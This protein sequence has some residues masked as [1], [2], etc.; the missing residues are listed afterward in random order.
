MKQLKFFTSQS[1]TMQA[2]KA[3]LIALG[4][5]P[6]KMRVFA[7]DNSRHHFD[8]LVMAS[9]RELEE[10][11]ADKTTAIYAVSCLLASFGIYAGWFGFVEFFA[12]VLLFGAVSMARH[13]FAKPKTL[14]KENQAGDSVYFFVV[15]V[16]DEKEARVSCL[17]KQCPGLIA[18]M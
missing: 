10:A 17:T 6:N 16:E 2:T 13:L 14:V 8:G 11:S 12:C 4:V 15:D 5:A 7:R 1:E 9:S 3:A 18:Q